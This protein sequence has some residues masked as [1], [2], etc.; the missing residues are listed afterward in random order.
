MVVLSLSM[1]IFG[2]RPSFRQFRELVQIGRDEKVARI[3]ASIDRDNR[4]MLTVSER[5]GFSVTYDVAEQLM[6]AQLAL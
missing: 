2:H 3:V 5:V 4:E 1:V 6:K